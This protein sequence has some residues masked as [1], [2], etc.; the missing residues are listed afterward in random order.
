M[1]KDLRKAFVS[2]NRATSMVSSTDC[3]CPAGKSGY[4][5]HVMALLLELADY[6]VRGL[7]KVLEEKAC[8]SV[9]RQCG[10][11]GNKDLQKAPV[12]STTIKRQA[13][14]QGYRANQ[15]TG[16]YM[17][18]TSVM[19]ELS[20]EKPPFPKVIVRNGL[21]SKENTELRP[22]MCSQSFNLSETF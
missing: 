8:P 14:K 11:L 16:F 9:A 1:K 10:I 4:C 3:S 7:K 5:N 22:A 12:M 13:E 20:T 17:I 19:K 6:S 15:W 18:R 2:I 21:L